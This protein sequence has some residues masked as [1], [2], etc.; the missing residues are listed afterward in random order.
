M[1]QLKSSSHWA[2]QSS[3]NRCVFSNWQNSNLPCCE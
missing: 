1:R 3:A 2:Q